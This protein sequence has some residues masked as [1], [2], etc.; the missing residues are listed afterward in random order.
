M[1][2]QK[3]FT[4]IIILGTVVAHFRNE[5]FF[6]FSNYPMYSR[7]FETDQKTHGYDIKGVNYDGTERS[8]FVFRYLYPLWSYALQTSLLAEEDDQ[9]INLKL[10]AVLKMH[11]DRLPLGD[12]RILAGMRIYEVKL[13]WPTIVDNLRRTKKFEGY[14]GTDRK[15]LYEAVR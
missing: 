6:P 14:L 2:F 10:N 9:K 1:F 5:D 7:V 4:V 8:I 3:I 13:D 12:P 15:I 11:N